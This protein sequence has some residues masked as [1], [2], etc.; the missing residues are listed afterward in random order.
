MSDLVGN[1]VFS[2]RC[3][4]D[5][6][7]DDND[8]KRLGYGELELKSVDSDFNWIWFC[9]KF[10]CFYVHFPF[11]YFLQFT[12]LLNS[13]WPITKKYFGALSLLFSLNSKKEHVE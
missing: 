12:V 1:L 5:F 10:Q 6:D 2:S 11:I 13:F 3:S 7:D 9:Y 8:N 4:Y